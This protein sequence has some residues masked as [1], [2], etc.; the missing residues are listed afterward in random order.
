MSFYELQTDGKFAYIELSHDFCQSNHIHGKTVIILRVNGYEY[1]KK[2]LPKGNSRYWLIFDKLTLKEAGL[3]IGQKYDFELEKNR[4]NDEISTEDNSDIR[5]IV[6]HCQKKEPEELSI[7]EGIFT[8]QSVRQFVHNRPP[9]NDKIE[10]ILKSACFA[11]SA[12]NKQPWEFIVVRD[13]NKLKEISIIL[14]KAGMAVSAGLV[15]VVCGNK[16]KESQT[17]FL[18]EDCSAAMQN[19][20]LC[21]HGLGLGAVWCGVYPNHIWTS[22]ITALFNLPRHI[23]PIGIIVIGHS[24]WTPA[25]PSCRF[26]QTIVHNESW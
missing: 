15:I 22:S 14:P 18:V 25:G 13:T 19:M 1:T 12:E 2:T 11:P 10:L 8:R 20:L 7:I 6:S 9:E 26:S 24:N 21:S 3:E 16:L 4:E 5:T 17:G 23:L